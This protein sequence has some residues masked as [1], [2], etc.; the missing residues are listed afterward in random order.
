MTASAFR[1]TPR[2]PSWPSA[3]DPP[4]AMR[5][6]VVTGDVGGRTPPHVADE[7]LAAAIGFRPGRQ[8]LAER[9]SATLRIELGR[10]HD[11]VHQADFLRARAAETRAR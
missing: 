6:A 5:L 11:R 4:L 7:R 8:D 2:S 10:R 1:E 9:S 3:R